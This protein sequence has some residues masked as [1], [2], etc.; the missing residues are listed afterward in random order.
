MKLSTYTDRERSCV[1]GHRTVKKNVRGMKVTQELTTLH[2]LAG[3]T[4][5]QDFRV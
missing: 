3:Q 1:L 4:N 5:T 2:T